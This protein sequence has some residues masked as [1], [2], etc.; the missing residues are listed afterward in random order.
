MHTPLPASMHSV[1]A[2]LHPFNT[3]Y[4]PL[5]H[6][7]NPGGNGVSDREGCVQCECCR[8]CCANCGGSNN[9]AD[10]CD[11]SFYYWYTRHPLPVWHTPYVH[12]VYLTGR[13]CVCVCVCVCVQ[14]LAAWAIHQLQLVSVRASDS[15]D[16][17]SDSHCQIH[18]VP[19]DT[20]QIP[21]D[22]HCTCVRYLAGRG[23]SC[24]DLL[25]DTRRVYTYGLGS[26]GCAVGSC[27]CCDGG[28]GGGG[29]GG[30]G[31]NPLA[32]MTN[33]RY[34]LPHRRYQAGD[35]ECRDHVINIT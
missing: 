18:S 8:S 19:V 14:V 26:Q 24:L 9:D 3:G 33:L 29:G 7:G 4:L 13:V 22:T 35:K 10:C 27:C 23:L 12:T 11:C 32:G 28:S 31:V 34:P 30:G 5:K 2:D 6:S 1:A 16:A 25:P 20:L 15:C 21:V 17:L